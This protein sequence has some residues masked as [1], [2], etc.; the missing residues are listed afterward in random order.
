MNGKLAKADIFTY[1]NGLPR[2]PETGELLVTVNFTGQSLGGAL[3]QYAAYDWLKDSTHSTD[4]SHVTL[5]TFNALGG[6][7]ALNNPLNEPAGYNPLALAGLSSAANFVVQ[8]DITSRLGGGFAAGS[9]YQMRYSPD[10][11]N[12]VTGQPYSETLGLIES[13]RIESGF[14]ANLQSDG[15]ASA[16]QIDASSYIIPSDNLAQPAALLGNLLNAK[17]PFVGSDFAD[18]L[19]GLSAAAAIAD[20]IQF[21]RLYKAVLQSGHETGS[22]DD[23]TYTVLNGLRYPT[24][25]VLKAIGVAATPITLLAAGLAD[26]FDL[27]LTG[28]QQAFSGVQQFLGLSPSQVPTPPVA[29]LSHEYEMKMLVYLS[30]IPGS[31][32]ASS[33]LAQELQ[34]ANIDP[35]ALAQQLLSTNGSAWRTDTLAYLR[36]QLPNPSDKVQ[37]NG[38]AIAFYQTLRA[39]PD[40]DPSD[41]TLFAQEQNTFIADMGFGFA[42]AIGDFTQKITN[43]AFSLGQTLTSF[44]DIQ[45]IDQAYAAELSDPRLSSAVKTVIEDARETF[46]RAAQTVVVQ[47]GIGS[48]PF[49]GAAFNPDAV[50]PAAVALN[51]GQVRAVTINLPYEAG[52]GGQRVQLTLAG[53]NAN[54]VTVLTGAGT[55]IPQNGVVLLTIP[56]GKRQLTVGLRSTQDV[57]SNSTLSI[58]ATLLDVAGVQ[59]HTTHIEA[60]VALADTGE[61]ADSELPVQG[62]VDQIWT[63]TPGDDDLNTVGFLGNHAITAGLGNDYVDGWSGDDR[64]E[65]EGGSDFLLGGQGRDV[66][67]GGDGIDRLEGDGTT[68]PLEQYGVPDEDYLDGGAGDDVLLGYDDD[69]VLLGGEGADQ[70]LGDDYPAGLYAGYPEAP[71]GRPMGADYLDGGAGADTL[72]GGLGEDVLLGG[73]GDDMLLGDNVTVGGWYE[74][75]YFLPSTPVFNPAGRPARFTVEGGADY[76]EGGA[77]DDILIGDG[78]DDLLLG[79]TENDFLFGDDLSTN[80]VVQGADWLEGGDGDDQLVGGG[81]TDVLAGGAGNDLLAGDF[82]G[83]AIAGADDSLDGGVGDDQLHGG[84]GNDVLEGGIGT[85]LLMGDDGQDSLYGGDGNDQLQG[86]LGDDVLDGESGNDLLFGGDGHDGLFGGDGIDEL[87]GGNGDD[88]LAG[89]AGDDFLLGDA[90]H[91][92]LFGDEGHDELQGGNGDDLLIGD[93]GN[94]VLF[95]QEGADQLF[96]DEGDDILNGGEGTNALVGGDGNDQLIGGSGEDRLEGGAGND[97]LVGGGGPDTIVYDGHGQDVLVAGVGDHLVMANGLTPETT[98][99]SRSGNDLVFIVNGTTNRLTMPA[100]F[101]SQANQVQQV[102]FADGAVWDQAMVVDQSRNIIGTDSDDTLTAPDDLGYRIQGRGSNDVLTGGGGVDMLQ[103]EVGLDT[104]RGGDGSD[105]L[106]G[107]I[108][109]DSLEGETGDDVLVGGTGDDQLFGGTGNDT[110]RFNLG[111]GLDSISDSI[112]VDEPNRVLFGPGFTTSSVTLTTNFSQ[113]VVRPGAA[114]EGVMVGANGNDALGFH[115][116]DYFDFADGTSLTYTQLVARGFDID[117][118]EFDDLLFGTNVID[119]FRGGLGS[120]RMEGGEGN[121]SFFFNV[122][123]GVDTIADTVVPGA[124]NEIVFGSGIVS[125]DLRL[126]LASE[127]SDSNIKDLLIRVGTNDD[128]VQLDTFDRDNAVGPRT[129][130]TFRFADGSTLTYDQLLARGFDLTGT[131]GDDQISGTNVTDRIVAG[132]GADV[133]RSG[134]GDDTLDGGF[135]NDRLIGGQGNDTY[136]FG[137]GSGQDTIVETQGNLDTIRM[138]PGVATSDVT[139]TRNS[140]DLVLSLNGGADQL[141]VSLY[142]LAPSLQ[143]ERVAFDDGTI[144]DQAVIEALTQ[145]ITTGTTGPDA[146]VG[147]TEDDR[148]VGLAGDDQLTGLAGRDVLD[149]GTGADQLTGGLG[150]DTYLVDDASDVVTEIANEGTDTIQ[151]AVSRSIEAHVENLTLTG[152]AAING[153]GNE[154]DNMLTGNSAAN[155]LTG[156]L[157][158]DAYVAGPEDMIVEL[159]GE[160]VDTVITDKNYRLG[161]NV[162]NLNLTG[163]QAIQGTGNELDNILAGNAS[164]DVL[165]GGIGN[166]TYVVKGLEQ[167]IETPGGGTDTVHSARTYRLGVSVENLILL[168]SDETLLEGLQFPAE[169]D[170]TGNELDNVLKGNKGDNRIDGLAGADR[171]TGDAGD[172]W[173]RVDN[174]GDIVIELFGEGMD[175]VESSLVSAW[176]ARRESLFARQ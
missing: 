47:Q 43:V 23:V 167:I 148:L 134:A 97:L 169:I 55:L 118:T 27:G 145:S 133:L 85:D 158:N 7:Y 30:D 160:G 34:V 170:A 59:T 117:G 119:R 91:D 16:Q 56:E 51:E 138:A 32:P 19:A 29:V 137:P 14:Y 123:D 110:Y 82:A 50:P 25:L 45:L 62:P 24:D 11:I 153:T 154:L 159:A 65:G 92:T 66:L 174:T 58:S 75:G 157:G 39:I 26:A 10:Q 150:D 124:D 161:A 54:T 172:D 44:A 8:G 135:G 142:F 40:L 89:E 2:N 69:D 166:D 147:T 22:L 52:T 20:P 164:L 125:S 90:G 94:D 109:D 21:D 67:Y 130:E 116:V 13:H 88:E 72:F 155:I 143:T 61:R 31:T 115:A 121:D 68:N 108:G 38:L 78:G 95:G 100:F 141:T 18:F 41:L 5:T 162:E 4:A 63:G 74:F 70:L 139:V 79:G 84:G 64:L 112:D 17:G 77:G 60:N 120:D 33:L 106:L 15:F 105:T 111:D 83:D 175:T 81:G 126:D 101:A 28:I 71:G 165:A 36:D 37:A 151:S 127:Q 146:L 129:V 173:Y 163:N 128:A 131:D 113:I 104:L 42:N 103:G 149:G 93:A 171:M 114:F 140:H 136:E 86:A 9:I 46:Q 102:Q 152:S 96:G 57:T 107:G 6:L 73:D 156:G 122:G 132:D 98:A 87:Q 1:L 176:C 168:D 76:L 80:T 35:D 3:A 53:P 12:P 48:N 49:N 144:W 99:A